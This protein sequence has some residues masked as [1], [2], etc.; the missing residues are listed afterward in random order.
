MFK[1]LIIYLTDLIVNSEFGDVSHFIQ[2]GT[3][4]V[5]HKGPTISLA[6]GQEEAHKEASR[7]HGINKP[8]GVDPDIWLI[9][10]L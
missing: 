6:D 8:P 5:V 9:N 2:H 7:P 1:T 10:L 4:G 3:T